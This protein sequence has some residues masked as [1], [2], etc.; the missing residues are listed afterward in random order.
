MYNEKV[1]IALMARRGSWI[2]ND[3]YAPHRCLF[4]YP[5]PMSNA[6]QWGNDFWWNGMPEIDSRETEQF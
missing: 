3:F 6:G 4:P 1:K 2:L 5:L